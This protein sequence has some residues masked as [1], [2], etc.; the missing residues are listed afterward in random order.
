MCWGCSTQQKVEL[1][2]HIHAHVH[3]AMRTTQALEA[4]EIGVREERSTEDWF[5][6]C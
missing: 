4:A 5:R 6:V 3:S 2:G 1:A